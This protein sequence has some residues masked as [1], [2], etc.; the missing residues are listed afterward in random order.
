MDSHIGTLE[1]P[2]ESERAG[3]G[4]FPCLLSCLKE[5]VFDS[6]WFAKKPR[7][8]KKKMKV[9]SKYDMVRQVIEC[10]N[11]KLPAHHITK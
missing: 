2:V 4:G 6:N 10:V 5:L 7:S 8:I 9:L 11:S 1:L 3:R